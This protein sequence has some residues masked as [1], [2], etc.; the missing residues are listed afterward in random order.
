MAAT[1]K[2]GS[3]VKRPGASIHSGSSAPVARTASLLT[4]EIQAEETTT[5]FDDELQRV[6]KE[7]RRVLN[8][9]Q[10]EFE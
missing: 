3:A 1:E 10:V 9:R 5:G 4:V 7:N 6:A 8:F 2:A